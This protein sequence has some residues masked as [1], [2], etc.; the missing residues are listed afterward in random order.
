VKYKL[1][2]ININ[3]PKVGKGSKPKKATATAKPVVQNKVHEMNWKLPSTGKNYSFK[4]HATSPSSTASAIENYNHTRSGGHVRAHIQTC[5][6]EVISKNND[7][8]FAFTHNGKEIPANK[9]EFDEIFELKGIPSQDKSKMYVR[10]YAW[11]QYLSPAFQYTVSK[12]SPS[13]HKKIINAPKINSKT[14]NPIQYVV[15]KDAC[16]TIKGN[17]VDITEFG[18]YCENRAIEQEIFFEYASTNFIRRL[19]WEI[20]PYHRSNGREKGH[21]VYNQL[22]NQ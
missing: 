22:T 1:K 16:K 8:T 13:I 17:K 18:I 4:V 11:L 2:Q 6:N 14:E 10:S 9:T 3:S 12:F 5:I 19:R 20:S 21:P 15:V 7:K